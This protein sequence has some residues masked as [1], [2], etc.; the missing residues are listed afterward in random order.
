[1]NSELKR[2]FTVPQAIGLLLLALLG[3][4]F[5]ALTKM[6]GVELTSEMWEK[7]LGD[8]MLAEAAL[9]Y[10]IYF[11]ERSIHSKRSLQAEE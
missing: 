1:M 4:Y 10:V 7:R 6:D 2:I 8:F 3:I 5:L 11:L 9:A